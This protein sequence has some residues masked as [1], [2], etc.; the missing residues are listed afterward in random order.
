MTA[1]LWVHSEQLHIVCHFDIG[2]ASAGD[3][4][5]DST[6]PGSGVTD[7]YL[8]ILESKDIRHDFDSALNQLLV[9][10]AMVQCVGLEALNKHHIENVNLIVYWVLSDADKI[11]W[12]TATK[13]PWYVFQ[14]S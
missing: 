13:T 12:S 10:L 1:S 11:S 4:S 8:A 3:P 2:S 6:T 14:S 9:Y 5:S 7:S